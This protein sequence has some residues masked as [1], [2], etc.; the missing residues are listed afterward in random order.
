MYR[1]ICILLGCV[2]ALLAE[3]PAAIAIR[4]A[5]VVTGTG[6]VLERGTV[7]L[8][9][10]LI[11]AVGEDPPLKPGVWVM[12][13]K[14]LTVYPGLIDALSS[15]GIPAGPP[16]QPAPQ[17]APAARGPEDR[18]LNTS[19]LR[20]AD[21]IQP[22]DPRIEAA[23]NA[24]FTTAVTFPMTGIFAGQGAVVNLAGER[25]G[26][27]V[28]AAPT[29]LYV[30]LGGAGGFASFPG[31]LMGVIA[32]L[33]Q[34]YI[35][36]DYYRVVQANY[37]RHPAGARRPAYDRAI[38]GLRDCPRVLLPAGRKVEMARMLRLAAELNVKPVLYGGHEAY[39][40]IQ[41]LKQSPVPVLVSLKWPERD[42]DADPELPES[43]RTLE[44]RES[45]PAGPAALAQAGIPFAFYSGGVERPRDLLKAVKRAID[46]GLSQQDAL[47]ALTLSTALI[48]GVADRLGSIEPG[49][50][51]NLVVTR[52]GLFDEKTEIQ[53][54]FIDGVKFEP[55]KET[56]GEAGK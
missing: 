44:T 19:W 34:S 35:D 38:E 48:Y 33:R 24:G 2:P 28:V 14:G 54:V 40:A 27:M 29:G 47:R 9:N 46:A 23:R 37:A 31:S 53:C 22:G 1:A 39:R 17:P 13:G 5:R 3:A 10:G 6:V 43:L 26:D 8:G 52:G 15:W 16:A 56:T 18:P 42:K 12:E 30:T 21:L 4:N 51:A 45:A 32:Y 49:K 7:V 25:A 55:P 41:T 11:E 36:A 50:I 20:A